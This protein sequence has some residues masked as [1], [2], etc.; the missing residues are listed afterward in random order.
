MARICMVGSWHQAMV[1]GAGLA[2]VGHDVTGVC[3]SELTAA[4]LNEGR[5]VVHEPGLPELLRRGIKRKRLRYTTDL[6]AA[7]RKAQFAYIAIDTPVRE[8]DSSDLTAIETAA[9]EIGRLHAGPLVLCVSAQVPVGTTHA[10]GALA[11]AQGGRGEIQVAYVPEFLRLGT[12][13]DTFFRADRVVVGADDPSVAKRVAAL[14]KALKRPI[15]QTNVRSAEM[16]KHASNTFLATS[17]SFINEIA[18]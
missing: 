12:A 17:I 9:R 13:L 7:L 14:Y 3:D 5:P 1:Y 16:A 11:N 4:S 18:N 15:L 8:D 6:A 10:L 2:S